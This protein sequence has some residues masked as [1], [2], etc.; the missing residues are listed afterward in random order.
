ML[1]LLRIKVVLVFW[2]LFTVISCRNKEQKAIQI[3]PADLSDI[4]VHVKRYGQALFEIDTA[5]FTEGLKKI[6][7]EFPYFLDADLNDT[8]NTNQLYSFVADTQVRRIYEKTMEVFP[9][10]NSLEGELSDAFSRYRYFFPENSLPQ[11]YTYV[12]DMYYEQPVWLRDSVLVVALDVYLGSDF[13]LYPHLGL[14]Q[15]KIRCMAPEYIATDVMKTLYFAEVWS[16]PAMKTLL[17]RMIAGGKILY[18][19]DAVLPNTPDTVKLCYTGKKLEWAVEN[20]KNIWAFLVHDELLY[21]SDF[22]TQSNLINDGPFTKGFSNDSP[23]RLGIFIGWQIVKEFMLRHPE[24]SLQE[25]MSLN[26]A[27]TILQQSGYKP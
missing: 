3:D 10:L 20:E 1:M 15:Y 4:Q 16:N 21:V 14:P 26:D 13:P 11:V 6:Q 22:D 9:D 19:L 12:S 23:A 8:A 24:T 2:V 27:Q 5:H 18:Y 7:P 17:D 25:L